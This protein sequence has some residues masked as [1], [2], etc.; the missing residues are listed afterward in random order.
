MGYFLLSYAPEISTI[1]FREKKSFREFMQRK[2][3][4][5]LNY[6][7]FAMNVMKGLCNIKNIATK[8]M[9]LFP[10]WNYYLQS[11]YAKLKKETNTELE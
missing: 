7:Y 6:K 1:I 4:W 5:W 8:F 11:K 2:K 9:K 3:I 10:T